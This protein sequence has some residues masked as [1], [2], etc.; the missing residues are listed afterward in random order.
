LG[1]NRNSQSRLAWSPNGK[2]LA[3]TD[4]DGVHVWE[5]AT[6]KEIAHYQKASNRELKNCN[7]ISW[8]PDGRALVLGME[9]DWAVV[10]VEGAA[11]AKQR[12]L[13]EGGFANV[14]WSPDGKAIAAVAHG[15]GGYGGWV[16]LHD[17]AT[18][19]QLRTLCEGSGRIEQFAWSPDGKT[20]AVTSNWQA[21]LASVDTGQFIRDLEISTNALAWSPDGKRLA[22]AGP[23][24]A[25]LLWE[26]GANTLPGHK[27][28]VKGLAWSPDGKR[29][30]SAATGEKRVLVW[31]VEKAELL[32]EIGPLAA[33]VQS[34]QYHRAWHPQK[35]MAWSPDCR[36]L[37]FHVQGVGWH[38][39]DVAQNKLANDPKQWKDFGFDFALDGRTALVWS[40]DGEPYRLR[41][42]DSGAERAQIFTRYLPYAALPAWSRDGHLLA[43]P[44]AC[45]IELW[46][47]DLRRRLW[48]LKA[49]GVPVRQIAFS[50]DGKLVAALAGER[51]HVWETDTGRLRG[52]QLPAK[53]NQSLAVS[54]DGH[55]AGSQ[56]ALRGI[57]IVVQKDD[58]A[59][60]VLEP[61][62]FE[63]KYG[64]KNDPEK[65]HLLEPLGP[66]ALVREPAVLPDQSATSWTIE[67]RN[68]RGRVKAVAYRP[69]GKL[70]ATGGDDG[71]IRIWDTARGRRQRQASARDTCALLATGLVPGWQ[72]SCRG[73]PRWRAQHR[74]RD[75][76]RIGDG[77]RRDAS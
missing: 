24:N 31:D 70:L 63:K 66:N 32:P 76:R 67:T 38:V 43:V 46:R 71:T 52:I 8:S 35:H 27:A 16:R 34:D 50:G 77:S 11:E 25:V 5:A 3:Q 21:F 48:A 74:R 57:V 61:A 40:G 10:E 55:Y 54:P 6:G 64:L 58:G 12:W 2:R 17:P 28:P 51:L 49:T 14:A 36:R 73:L 4:L 19:K 22:A 62:E 23:E 18:G 56:E 60:E 59:Q 1:Q 41:D 9:H 47:S 29:L 69:D 7:Y 72:D 26:D 13:K 53:E 33:A 15:E 42:L 65:V 39:W 30:A 20:L 44:V 68:A 75:R 45:G 37:A